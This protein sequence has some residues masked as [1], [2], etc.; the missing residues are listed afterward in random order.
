VQRIEYRMV[1]EL[2]SKR[3]WA[4]APRVWL[5]G[6]GP[7]LREFDWSLLAGEVVVG[8]NRCYERPHVGV[9]VCVDGANAP[10]FLSWA[11]LGKF[12]DLWSQY[13]GL[14]VYSQL[15]GKHDGIPADVYVVK[16]RRTQG[17]ELD[18]E[19]GLPQVNNTGTLALQF[20]AALG[21]KDIRLL[22]FDMGSPGEKQEHHHDGYPREQSA[23][24]CDAMIPEFGKLAPQLRE[25]GVSVTQYGESR[26]TCFEKY[27]LEVAVEELQRKPSRPLV[28]CAITAGTGYVREVE[29]MVR[30][31]RAMGLEVVVEQYESRGDW[32]LNTHYKP[33]FMEQMLRKYKRPILWLDADSRVRQYP[34]L[35]DDL[36]ADIGWVWW[37]WDEI[38][39]NG[40]T[41]I[42]LSTS[43]L[44][45]RPKAEVYRLLGAWQKANEAAP[46]EHDQDN[47]QHMLEGG[48]KQGR[49]KAQQL[50][51]GYAQI[52]DLQRSLGEPVIEQMQ[53]SRR[54]RGRV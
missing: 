22:G 15:E 3:A 16:R 7:S 42:E 32:F 10:G 9:T 1:H 25:L 44:Y 50:P 37:D 29:E 51:M 14:K 19:G 46:G 34:A 24:V 12:G 49:L 38:G 28:V 40:I 31:A 53:A 20:A 54:F 27:P 41:G 43:I 8:C 48:F 11:E 39:R 6:G 13:T 45:L 26:L 33:V 4:E 21:A 47:L 5:V 35:F 52:F 36:T 23:N 30:T 2:L 18:V 17:D